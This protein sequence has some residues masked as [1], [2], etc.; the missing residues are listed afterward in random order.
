MV[1]IRSLAP[2][3][4]WLKVIGASQNTSLPSRRN[5]SWGCTITV[6]SR[7]PAGP[8]FFPALPCPRREMV[9]PWSI[10][11]GMLTLMV[12]RLR[13][14]P[15]PPQSVQGWWMILPV[16][17]QRW[18]GR[19]LANTPIGVRCCTCTTPLP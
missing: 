12:L 13:T 19:L 2:N 4:A 15:E 1:G 14:A 16:P 17:R 8:P 3:T 6:I 7:S 10:P 18:Q 5:S 11:A 9:C